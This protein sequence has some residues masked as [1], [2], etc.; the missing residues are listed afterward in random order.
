MAVEGHTRDPSTGTGG[1][2]RNIKSA[3]QNVTTRSAQDQPGLHGTQSQRN[4]KQ[5]RKQKHK[6][7]KTPS[8]RISRVSFP[9]FPRHTVL[10]VGEME[11]MGNDLTFQMPRFGGVSGF[12]GSQ[13]LEGLRAWRVSRFTG[14]QLLEGLGVC[15]VSGSAGSRSL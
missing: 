8:L 14:P 4:K 3:G 5:T 11:R 6:T 10:R 12:E 9:Y 15:R 13:G 2:G 1:R 7:R